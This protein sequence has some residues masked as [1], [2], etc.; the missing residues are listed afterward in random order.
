MAID[1]EYAE[2][3]AYKT[4]IVERGNRLAAIVERI[5]KRDTLAGSRL[6][7]RQALAA[8]RELPCSDAP[9]CEV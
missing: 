2:R 8:W 5:L 1:Y 6:E 4:A 3:T 9:D 7:L